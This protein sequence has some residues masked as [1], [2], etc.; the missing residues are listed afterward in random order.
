MKPTSEPSQA[1]LAFKAV[2]ASHIASRSS[3]H[4]KGAYR[5]D[6]DQWVAHCA[7]VGVDPCDP[8]EG[9]AAFY[10]DKLRE[11]DDRNEPSKALTIRRKLASLSSIYAKAKAAKVPTVTWNPFDPDTLDWPPSSSYSKTLAVSDSDVL[12]VIAA[13]EADSGKAGARDAAVLWLLYETGLRRASVAGV[14]RENLI[15]I[16]GVRIARVVIKG[17]EEEE[18]ELAE[19]TAVAIDRWLALAPASAS[20]CSRGAKVDRSTRRP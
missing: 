16:D 13:A 12:K 19:R 11:G 14:R 5:T 10:R 15:E 3:K 4:T 8:P 2:A 6:F 17:G 9:A 20:S 7:L 1:L 18:V